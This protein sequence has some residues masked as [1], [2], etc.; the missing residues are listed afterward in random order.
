MKDAE[1]TV[2]DSFVVRLITLPPALRNTP[3]LTLYNHK[4]IVG[5]GNAEGH[6]RAAKAF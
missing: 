5:Q 3:K 6:V 4:G 1:D 2:E